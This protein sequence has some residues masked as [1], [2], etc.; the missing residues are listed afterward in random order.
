LPNSPGVAGYRIYVGFALPSEP[1]TG[2][3]TK[4]LFLLGRGGW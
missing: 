1:T 3:E 4:L 2:G